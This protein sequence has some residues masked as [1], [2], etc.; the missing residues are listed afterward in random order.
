[1]V[2]WPHVWAKLY[3]STFSYLFEDKDPSQQRH[4]TLL[5]FFPICLNMNCLYIAAASTTASAAVLQLPPHGDPATVP[6]LPP[7]SPR[8][9]SCGSLQELQVHSTLRP[10]ASFLVWSAGMC[11]LDL[12]FHV[13]DRRFWLLR[14][15]GSWWVRGLGLHSVSKKWVFF[16]V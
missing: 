11:R 3:I 13:L 14:T 6:P 7:M 4:A 2:I 15:C 5:N 8:R 12:R 10:N 9:I 1:M 16:S